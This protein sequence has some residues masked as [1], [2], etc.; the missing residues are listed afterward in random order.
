MFNFHKNLKKLVLT[1]L[2][3]YVALSFVIAIYP[4]TDLQYVQPLPTAPEMTDSERRG[5]HVYV[6]ENC[7]ACHTQQVRSI[8]MD[9][10]WGS[11]PSIPSD[12][13]YDKQRQDIWRQSPSL[14]GSERTGPDLTS[15]GERQPDQGWHLLHLYN[16]RSV[17]DASIMPSYPWMFVEK[18]SA[19]LT[20]ED[21]VVPV[22]NEFLDD[23]NKKIVATPK[24]LDLVAYLQ[25]L[26]QAPMPGSESVA[27]IP[28]AK[29]DVPAGAS[30]EGGSGPDG[31]AIYMASCAACHQKAGTGLPG[32]FPSLVGSP[33][34][35]DED[36][37]L[38]IEIILA[39]Y[40]ARSEFGVMPPFSN[41]LTDEEI[42]AVATHERSSWGNDAPPVTAEKVKEIR[43]YMQELAAAE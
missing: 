14:L 32:A 18:D 43:T 26:R 39:G 5:L 42:A 15:V 31:A 33:I 20:E 6:S 29:E 41:Q 13:Y 30:E 36:P 1:A 9:E 37:T 27:F 3:V 34:V 28:S 22:P 17:V 10:V 8:E 19:E 7:M 2:G 11:R 40:D 16:P 38:M 12:Y 21:V 25:S 23:P 24:A 4:A 35:T